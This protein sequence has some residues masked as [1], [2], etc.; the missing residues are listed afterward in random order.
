MFLLGAASGCLKTPRLE[1]I[2]ALMQ[3][4]KKRSI[5]VPEGVSNQTTHR[6]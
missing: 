4:Q 6:S 1:A 5:L 2:M 3:H